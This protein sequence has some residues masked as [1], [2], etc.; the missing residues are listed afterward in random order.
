M[1]IYNFIISALILLYGITKTNCI[2]FFVIIELVEDSDET[3]LEEETMV[4][5]PLID[6][7]GMYN[8][9]VTIDECI[10][11]YLF[12][13]QVNKRGKGRTRSSQNTAQ[14]KEEVQNNANGTEGS[15]R[16]RRRKQEEL[17]DIVGKVELPAK[18]VRSA[19]ELG[20]SRILSSRRTQ[21]KGKDVCPRESLRRESIRGS[22]KRAAC[23]IIE[24]TESVQSTDSEDQTC[25]SK[26]ASAAT[27]QNSTLGRKRRGRPLLTENAMEVVE[28]TESVDPDSEEMGN[29]SMLAGRPKRRKEE[30]LGP[31]EIVANKSEKENGSVQASSS[32]IE[33]GSSGRTPT[34]RITPKITMSQKQRSKTEPT[35]TKVEEM[36]HISTAEPTKSTDPSSEELGSSNVV[37]GRQTRRRGRKLPMKTSSSRGRRLKNSASN[38]SSRVSTEL[39]SGSVE[40]DQLLATHA[41][42]KPSGREVTVAI[43]QSSDWCGSSGI[44]SDVLSVAD[45]K[46]GPRPRHNVISTQHSIS[47]VTTDLGSSSKLVGKKKA[48]RKGAKKLCSKSSTE[49]ENF[50]ESGIKSQDSPSQDNAIFSEASMTTEESTQLGNSGTRFTAARSTRKIS[51]E[52]SSATSCSS[53]DS[54]TSANDSASLSSATVQPGPS[55]GKNTEPSMIRK[56]RSKTRVSAVASNDASAPVPDNA[57]TIEQTQHGNS[58]DKMDSSSKRSPLKQL[59]SSEDCEESSSKRAK[60]TMSEADAEQ[61]SAPQ[62]G[63]PSAS[64]V[65]AMQ[66]PSTPTKSTTPKTFVDSK[67]GNS[68]SHLES[69]QDKSVDTG[70]NAN[71]ESLATGIGKSPANSNLLSAG[72]SKGMFDSFFV[73]FFKECSCALV[74]CI[75]FCIQ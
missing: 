63:V 35:E 30:D 36:E 65:P 74:H 54:L 55:S 53:Q 73:L 37:A 58:V 11:Y 50:G 16:G 64:A 8:E 62:N 2:L 38:A 66:S 44:V 39:D 25:A 13:F 1:V 69:K 10:Y 56:T 4:K 14:R 20:S 75:L 52:A 42:L 41:S 29:S 70:G 49:D 48:Q 5:S 3:E 17:P 24:S 57:P 60:P 7:K 27:R 45:I 18:S 33:L 51:K 31:K 12:L 40:S 68:V 26:S 46:A 61:P 15:R 21:R 28:R 67:S 47:T 34:L 71:G 22:N 43:S 9:I 72:P 59:I 19:E 6:L 32:D 23:E